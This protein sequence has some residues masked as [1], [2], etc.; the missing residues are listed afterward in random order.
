MKAPL[1]KDAIG[2]DEQVRLLE[3]LPFI[4]DVR[5]SPRGAQTPADYDGRIAIRT[6]DETFHFL[7]DRK[8]S[9]L[10]RAS[11]NALIA[12]DQRTRRD[13]GH[14]LLLFARYVPRPTAER[15]MAADLN[16]IDLA[17]NMHLVLGPRYHHTVIG[18]PEERSRS[19]KQLVNT[20]QVQVLFALAA[21]PESSGWPVRRL[22]STAGVSKSRAAQIRRDLAGKR[23]VEQVSGG[24]VF[25]DFRWLQERLVNGY[26]EVLRPKLAV[27]R[28]RSPY[29]TP[30]EFIEKLPP[31]LEGGAA[32]F[33]ITG[34][35]ASHALQRFY[36]GQD[37]PV[38]LTDTSTEVQQ[39]LRLLPDRTGAVT[40]LRAFGELPFWRNV[41]G[42]TV[43][44]P[45]LIYTELMNST[46]SRAHE[47]AEELRREFLA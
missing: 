20:A 36:H 19:E 23:I 18:R 3:T 33:A 27:G 13:Q 34:G 35:P 39:K 1:S 10:D 31:L 40:L 25:R 28:F 11:T 14:P 29:K 44:H 43:A 37:V 47:A 30:E 21:H 8:K 38:F 4:K 45:W 42:L 7:L 24:Q 15:F 12:L 26:A 46:D 41:G 5:R 6:P 9:Y 32:K 17:G 16:F 22:A 2:V